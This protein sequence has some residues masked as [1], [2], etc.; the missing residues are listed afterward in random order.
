M[1]QVKLFVEVFGALLSP[2]IAIIVAYI[3]YQQW[4]VNK[5]KETRESNKQKLHVYLS[6]KRFLHSFDY[7]KD[8]DKTLYSE[9]Q[10]ALAIGDFLFDSDLKGW[11]SDIDSDIS[12]YINTQ[13]VIDSFPIEQT[14]AQ[15]EMLEKEKLALRN[16]ESALENYHCELYTRFQGKILK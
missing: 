11:L 1:E 2:I 9:M 10:E 8:V 5:N 16:Y 13:E 3:A 7:T 15:K 4:K 6:V 14:E 12:C